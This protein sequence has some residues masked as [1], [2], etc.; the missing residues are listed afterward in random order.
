[1]RLGVCCLVFGKS[2]VLMLERDPVGGEVA[3][4]EMIPAN[5]FLGTVEGKILVR[6]HVRRVM[7][8]SRVQEKKEGMTDQGAQR[9]IYMPLVVQSREPL[10]DVFEKS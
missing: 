5:A 6:E 9:G 2:Q 7:G 8:M 10:R 4:E 1:M 3:I